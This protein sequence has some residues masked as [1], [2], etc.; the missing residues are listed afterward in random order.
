MNRTI[1]QNGGGRTAPLLSGKKIPG[2]V[3]TL[4]LLFLV[5][6][7]NCISEAHANSPMSGFNPTYLADTPDGLTVQA[8]T[9]WANSALPLRSIYFDKWEEGNF[10][11]DTVNSADT[12]WQADTG[13]VYNSWRLAA[14]YRGELFL[15]TNRDTI[16]VLHLIET[17]QKLP[18]G[19][20]FSIDLEAEGFSAYGIELAKGLNLDGI[21]PGLRTGIAVRYL[22]GEMIQNAKIMGS[23]TPTGPK[24][25]DFDLLLDYTYDRSIIYRRRNTVPGR[26]DGFSFDV[27]LDYAWKEKF[28]GSLL[29]RD[30]FG[31]IF[32]K[33]MPYT[34]ADATSEVKTYDNHGYQTFRPT[35]R[36]FEGYRS[37]T[38][39]IPLK[40]DI[41]L[42]YREGP[43][44]LTTTLNLVEDRPLYWVD[45]A[46][47]PFPDLLVS[48]GYNINY[49]AMVIGITYRNATVRLTA[50]EVELS[51]AKA[52]GFEFTVPYE[53]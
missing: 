51:R 22:N 12:W 1:G 5:A 6:L 52:L 14:L 25:Y 20:T 41:D 39:K 17:R 26:G 46:L 42:W 32:W 31:R 8:R 27:G 9:F 49:E 38:Q 18:V 11:P 7:L 29:V 10:S 3:F 43:I 4:C 47:R 21:L 53:W 40:T 16:E 13:I 30:L 45:L 24:T 34:Y 28:G 35:I 2:F 36:G 50:D 19:R 37:F 23:A 15:E 44:T 48:A 33:D